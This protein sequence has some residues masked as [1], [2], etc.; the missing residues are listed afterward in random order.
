MNLKYVKI[1]PILWRVKILYVL[2]VEYDNSNN[3]FVEADR[4]IC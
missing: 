3:I 2:I 1:K 4:G